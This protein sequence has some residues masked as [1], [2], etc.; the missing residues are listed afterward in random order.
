MDSHY[1]TFHPTVSDQTLFPC[2]AIGMMYMQNC[3][4]SRLEDAG[5]CFAMTECWSEAAEVYFKAK[6][7]TKCF[8]MCSKGKLFSLGLQFLQQLWEE[9][10]VDES[11]IGLLYSPA[12]YGLIFESLDA[13]LRPSNK[14][15]THGHLGRMAI[16]LLHVA[17][18]GGMLTSRLTQYLDSESEW[19]NFFRSLDIFVHNRSHMFEHIHSKHPS[20]LDGRYSLLLKFKLALEST[21]KFTLNTN[22]REE[23]DYIS[24]LCYVDLIECLGHVASSCFALHGCMFSTQSIV[25][26]MTKRKNAYIYL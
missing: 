9:A 17:P 7:Y 12:A 21:F 19:T 3:S 5:D 1:F 6:C 26:K 14:K 22:W 25:V 15:L 16:L 23:P 8:S 20:G 24:P 4:T 13:H 10:S 11:N 18:W 2:I